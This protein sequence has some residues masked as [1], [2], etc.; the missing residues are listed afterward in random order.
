M[1]RDR[2]GGYYDFHL[3]HYLHRLTLFLGVKILNFTIL[4]GLELSQL[5]CLGMT[6]CV[7]IFGVCQFW[8]VF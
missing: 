8:Q 3:L 4:G 6:I 2:E 7:A 1:W 5:F